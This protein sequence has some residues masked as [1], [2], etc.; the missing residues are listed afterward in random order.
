MHLRL[1]LS[2][3]LPSSLGFHLKMT[4]GKKCNRY[5][6]A[7]SEYCSSLN[8]QRLPQIERGEVETSFQRQ[9]E[10]DTRSL[11]RPN[12]TEMSRPGTGLQQ[13]A[14]FW[15]EL[16]VDCRRLSW[17][18]GGHPGLREAPLF[19]HRANCSVSIFAEEHCHTLLT[20]FRV[21]STRPALS[22]AML[23][24]FCIL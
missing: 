20:P 21:A 15:N 12:G 8:L 1:N 4:L 24:L 17:S 23:S 10:P 13:F 9:V 6:A 5:G 19:H 11:L 2:V 18:R 16:R 22:Q 7:S 3:T 14:F